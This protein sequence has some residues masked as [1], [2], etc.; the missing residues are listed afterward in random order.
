[1]DL[2]T[3]EPERRWTM[4]NPK[5]CFGIPREILSG[6]KRV[7]VIPETVRKMVSRG[8]RVLIEQ[9]AGEGSHYSDDAYRAAGG[10]I[11][12]DVGEV[13]RGA[14]V[15]LKVKEP[16][17]NALRNCHEVDMMRAGQYLV[18]F[19]HPANPGNH[20]MVRKLADQ[21][22]ISLTLDSVPRI[23]RAQSMD[24]LTSMSTVAGYKGVLIAADLLPKFM[25]MVGTATG[26]IQPS[27]ALVI[28]AG[29]AGLQA[30]ATAK[31]LGAV[32][33][34]ADIRP[35]AA[36]QAASV[37]AKIIDLGIPS[38]F[39]VGSGGYA[40]KLPDEWLRHERETLREH[41]AKA[42][43]I[44]LSALIPG[45][46]AP[47]IIT[48]D[49]VRSMN[50]GSVIVDIAIDQGGNCELTEAGKTVSKNEVTIVGIQNIP[51]MVAMSSTWMFANNMY[52]FVDNLLKDDAVC[53]DKGDE[54]V[55][56]CLLTLDR[57]IVHT[58]ARE[59]M[60]L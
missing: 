4:S 45:K 48:D 43:I 11:V 38:E 3:G 21:G 33:Q 23:S 9:G 56:S 49:M 26:M 17:Y 14:D 58:G 5:V 57:K 37:G 41:V 19:L 20:E 60:G 1:M 44:I 15:I 16:K 36:E 22:V 40:R 8:A 12:T 47:V 28:G 6:E 24:A 30:I 2:R 31:R 39:T 32:V 50:S 27:R 51:G 52:N 34:A 35:D 55:A 59:A 25:P 13:Y 54:I 7:A 10:E 29:V 18:A 46:L 42:D 53:L